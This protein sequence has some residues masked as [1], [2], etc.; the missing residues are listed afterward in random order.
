MSPLWLLPASIT[1]ASVLV[2]AASLRRVAHEA[3]HLRRSLADWDRLAVATGD[4]AH[5]A[6]AAERGLRRLTRR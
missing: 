6:R 3:Q 5:E 1:L 4:L 2:L